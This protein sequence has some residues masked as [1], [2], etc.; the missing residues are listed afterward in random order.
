MNK[1]NI[2]IIPHCSLGGGAGIYNQ[3][4][5][6][7]LYIKKNV[8][9]CGIFSKH[10]TQNI[11]VSKIFDELSKI[12]FP[13]Y[14]GISNNKIIYHLVKSKIIISILKLLSLGKYFKN[15][16]H[17]HA[18]ILTSGIQ[19]ILIPF[20]RHLFP[21]CKIVIVIQEFIALDTIFGKKFINY[22]NENNTIIIS[23]TESW[24]KF[25][26]SYSIHTRIIKNSFLSPNIYTPKTIISSDL[27]YVGGDAEI[28]GFKNMLYI[29]KKLIYIR[30][31][32]IIFLG[33]Y[34][35]KSINKIKNLQNATG[36]QSQLIIEG[37]QKNIYKYLL[38]TKLLVLPIQNTHFCRPAIE[39][40]ICRKTFI[41]PN[42]NN[43]EDFALSDKNCLMYKFGDYYDGK[44][45]ILSLLDNVK[46]RK[47]LEYNNHRFSKRFLTNSQEQYS[48]N[49]FLS[50]VSY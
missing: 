26:A 6:E 20:L 7:T 19:S 37:L 38:G 12:C 8:Y 15:T 30:K 29:L 9:G 33:V 24:A 25:A 28:K 39:A 11:Y 14:S 42:L 17:P 1:T 3:K 49:Q 50:L 21:K 13:V 5:F 47:N 18:I 43:L 23:I 41:I 22:V 36:N 27:L 31:L 34:N 32:K 45:Q 48:F 46:L 40:G 2:L 4:I 16:I 10:Y 44:E 35:V